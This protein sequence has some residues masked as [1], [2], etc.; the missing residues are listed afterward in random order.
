MLDVPHNEK[1]KTFAWNLDENPAIWNA[2][3]NATRRK[4]LASNPNEDIGF[5]FNLPNPPNHTVAVGSTQPLTEMSARNLPEGSK[6]RP[7]RKSNNF[8]TVSAD[9]PENVGTSTSRIL[10]TSAA[11]YRDSYTY[12]RLFKDAFIRYG[13]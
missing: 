8:T 4:A 3:Q 9:Y 2:F 12:F 1:D 10:W 5:F 11:C 13:V 7:E 6:A